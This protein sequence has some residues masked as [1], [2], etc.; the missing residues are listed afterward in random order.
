[1][2]TEN[3]SFWKLSKP[4]QIS[5]WVIALIFGILMAILGRESVNTQVNANGTYIQVHEVRINDI[6][7]D[8]DELKQEIKEELREQRIMI[9][10]IHKIIMDE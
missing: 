7:K 4:A 3:D 5:M 10:D 1:M 8:A 2:F 9:T 6:E